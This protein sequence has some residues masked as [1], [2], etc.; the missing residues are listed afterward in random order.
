M[1]KRQEGKKGTMKS[2]EEPSGF[3]RQ[4]K[5]GGRVLEKNGKENL[6]GSDA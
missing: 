3:G 4:T 6:K 2:E 1:G 5:R